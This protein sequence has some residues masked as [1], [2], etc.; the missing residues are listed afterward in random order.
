MQT[1][2]S[3]QVQAEV[4][5]GFKGTDLGIALAAIAIP[6]LSDGLEGILLGQRT[7]NQLITD[8]LRH[9]LT[10]RV[11]REGIDRSLLLGQSERLLDLTY[12]RRRS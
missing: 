3:V 9:G 7:I 6:E 8:R 12:H 11:N 5:P 4:L 1:P 10:S 2:T